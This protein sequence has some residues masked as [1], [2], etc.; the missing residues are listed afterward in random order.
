MCRKRVLN[1]PLVRRHALVREPQAGRWISGLPEDVD[2]DA[3]ARK[4]IAADAQ[5]TGL[6]DSLDLLADHQRAVLMEVTVVAKAGKIKL[7]GLAFD[8]ARPRGVVDHQM[9]EVGLAG[10][11]AQVVNSGQ[12]KRTR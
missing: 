2:G 4:P 7:Q 5:P 10:D 6:G 11:R 8:Q 12:V 9:R 1:T 3:A